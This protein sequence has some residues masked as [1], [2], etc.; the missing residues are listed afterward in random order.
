MAKSLTEKEARNAVRQY[1]HG[2]S[3]RILAERYGVSYGN[4]HRVLRTAKVEMR[5]RG[6]NHR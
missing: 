5:P 3:V 1:E 2:D 4:I 6:G